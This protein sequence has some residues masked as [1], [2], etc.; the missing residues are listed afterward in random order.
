M[1]SHPHACDVEC[2]VS[3]SRPKRPTIGRRESKRK[4]EIPKKEQEKTKKQNKDKK[5]TK[6]VNVIQVVPKNAHPS[7]MKHVTGTTTA[8]GSSWH[9][10]RGKAFK[11]SLAVIGASAT[12]R[13]RALK[14]NLRQVVGNLLGEKRRKGGGHFRYSRSSPDHIGAGRSTTPLSA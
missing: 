11:S 14:R 12:R 10:L 13:S 6:K 2:P 3:P 8:S 4:N 1:P 5:H 7:L 9:R